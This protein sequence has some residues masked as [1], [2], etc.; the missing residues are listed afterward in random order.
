VSTLDGSQDRPGL[1]TL[2]RLI[3]LARRGRAR[4]SERAAVFSRWLRAQIVAEVDET[5]AVRTGSRLS[6]FLARRHLVQRQQVH[7]RA[8][9]KQT[10]VARH[11]LER[12]AQLAQPRAGEG[13]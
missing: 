11:A 6:R 4:Y 5:G 3:A 2:E 12:A 7:R 1:N 10:S 13:R 9:G 8:G